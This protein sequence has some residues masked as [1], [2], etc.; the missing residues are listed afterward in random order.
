[1]LG[2][3]LGNDD[4]PDVGSVLGSELGTVL[5]LLEGSSLGKEV[6]PVV[7]SSLGINEGS[8]VGSSLCDCVGSILGNELFDGVGLVLGNEFGI[9][10]GSDEGFI[11]VSMMGLELSRILG[12]SL[13]ID[14]GF[15]M[16]MEL[17][18]SLFVM[19]LGDEVGSELVRFLVG[20][21][22][23]ESTDGKELWALLGQL[24][25]GMSDKLGDGE[26]LLLVD[27]LGTS[28]FALLGFVLGIKLGS[29]PIIFTLPV[30]LV[31]LGGADGIDDT[32]SEN[33]GSN[34]GSDDGAL[35]PDGSF[36]SMKLSC[37]GPSDGVLLEL[38]DGFGVAASKTAVGVGVKY[39][40]VLV[41]SSDT[42]GS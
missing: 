9:G 40:L 25:L 5:G 33:V 6:G 12:I 22:D 24:L 26:G 35:V 38:L 36:V 2:N 42:V 3:S 31:V 10:V 23:D 13:G 20:V 28:L 15:L 41:G 37:V 32:F 17:L 18:I 14:D 27:K 39:R 1:M 7:G 11:L 21:C 19:E 30:V 4:G 34:V 16:G 29:S 8:E